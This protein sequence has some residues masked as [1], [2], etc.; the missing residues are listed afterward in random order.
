MIA[1]IFDAQI[2]RLLSQL[3]E[4]EYKYLDSNIRVQ[5]Y[6]VDGSST[7]AAEVGPGVLLERGDTHVGESY[8]RS[9]YRLVGEAE[10]ILQFAEAQSIHVCFAPAYNNGRSREQDVAVSQRL[11]AYASEP[12]KEAVC[13]YCV[14]LIKDE[15]GEVVDF[16]LTPFTTNQDGERC[17]VGDPNCYIAPQDEEAYATCERVSDGYR[18]Q[19]TGEVQ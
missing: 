10:A 8:D 16:R 11:R 2:S 15:E 3:G 12:L 7:Y 17:A 14:E 19:V 18:I 1:T 4:I 6:R 5:G 9:T 13:F